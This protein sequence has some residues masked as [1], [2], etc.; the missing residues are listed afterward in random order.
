MAS[1]ST[2]ERVQAVSQFLL[3]SPP[4]EINDVLNGRFNPFARHQDH[5]ADTP[6]IC[7]DVR[8]LV[9]DDESLEAGVLP[10][11]QQYNLEQFTVAEVPG[12]GHT[13]RIAYSG[14]TI[15]T[16]LPPLRGACSLLSVR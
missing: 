12:A 13:V 9:G 10:A 15:R 16:H 6:P 5:V 8:M 3:Q 4:G 1:M 14:L 7:T 2:E 11:L